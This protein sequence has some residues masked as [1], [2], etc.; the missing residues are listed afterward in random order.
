MNSPRDPRRRS[1]DP[2]IGRVLAE[3]YRI[4]GLLGEGAIG[5]VYRGIREADQT[6]VAIKFLHPPWAK[7]A[8]YR[9]R[10]VREARLLAK[11]KHPSLVQVLDFGDE[12][13][14]PYLVMELLQGQ[15]LRTVM[16]QGLIDFDRVVHII[17]EVL[18]VLVLAHSEG[19]VHRDL[20]PDNVMLLNT[21]SRQ[22]LVKVF[23][24]GLAF[25]D[26]QPGG[27]RLTEPNSVRGTPLYM[28]PEQCRGKPVTAASDVYS[29]GVMLFELLTGRVPFG[30]EGST[31]V[32]AQHVFVPPP[33]M[34]NFGPRE[35][36]AVLEA[37]TLSA[38][39]KQAEL[40]PTAQELQR[41]LLETLH[42]LRTPS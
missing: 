10:F 7:L 24:F 40:R 6:P 3:R 13:E 4:D 42:T 20:K 23:D 31:D 12:G 26:D 35:V 19:V 1:S 36:P 37:V 9:A 16:Q 22:E 25:A 32:M 11:L 18:S 29:V 17:A 34:E 41:A 33:L 14:T 39:Q 8:E 28:A 21:A 5:V 15:T 38:L 27:Q 30:D 2:R